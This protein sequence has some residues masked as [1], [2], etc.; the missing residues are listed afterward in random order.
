MSKIIAIT[1]TH[2][3]GKTTLSYQL[4]A[5]YKQ[6]GHNVKIIQEVARSCPFPINAGMTTETMLWIFF[7]HMRKELEAMKSHDIVISDRT[8]F[9]SFAYGENAGL[10]INESPAI[11]YKEIALNQLFKSYHQVFWLRPDMD[12]TPDGTRSTDIEF[13]KNVDAVFEKYLKDAGFAQIKSSEL[14]SG[15]EVWKQYC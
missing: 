6:L 5:H 15:N 3:T 4:A 9:D 13:Q 12:I 14:F 10:K 11:A 7:E 2:G 1:G 8:V